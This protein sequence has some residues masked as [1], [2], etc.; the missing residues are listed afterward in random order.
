M[1]RVLN[2]VSLLKNRF[3]VC[4]SVLMFRWKTPNTKHQSRTFKM[5][6]MSPSSAIDYS[7]ATKVLRSSGQRNYQGK[8]KSEWWIERA[9]EWLSEWICRRL[10]YPVHYAARIHGL[11]R[12]K[13]SY[14]YSP[15][16]H[17][18]NKS[19]YFSLF[20]TIAQSYMNIYYQIQ[21]IP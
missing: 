13:Y 3:Q 5:S 1:K 21:P 20:T 12:H 15:E 2:C 6:K 17:K 9:S 14:N 18:S 19:W 4:R 16:H 8:F 10:R 7:F 11:K